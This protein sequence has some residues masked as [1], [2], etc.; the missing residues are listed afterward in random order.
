MLGRVDLLPM[1]LAE[2]AQLQNGA[3]LRLPDRLIEQ[4]DDLLRDGA[5]LVFRQ[6]ADLIIEII[7]K[8]FNV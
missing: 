3:L 5:A 4:V 8:L 1:F 7:R 6:N 2:T